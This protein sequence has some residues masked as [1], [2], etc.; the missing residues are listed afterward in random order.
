MDHWRE[1]FCN[2]YVT[3]ISI[4]RFTS[5]FVIW[6]AKHLGHLMQDRTTSGHNPGQQNP[7]NKI[8]EDWARDTVKKP[9]KFRRNLLFRR[10][11]RSIPLAT[12]WNLSL[13]LSY[14]KVISWYCYSNIDHTICPKISFIY[15]F[16]PSI[17]R[18]CF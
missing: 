12:H 15:P 10:N 5:F 2:F 14:S 17:T 18:L 4:T 13:S 6:L 8:S 3:S 1:F 9:Y 7:R 11:L 16:F